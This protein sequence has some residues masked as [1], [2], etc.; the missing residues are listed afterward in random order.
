[1]IAP[2]NDG[3]GAGEVCGEKSRPRGGARDGRRA[4]G[5]SEDGGSQPILSELLGKAAGEPL[6]DEVSAVR[7][8]F[9]LLGF[10]L[11]A[12]FICQPTLSDP[13]VEQTDLFLFNN[14]KSIINNFLMRSLMQK[15]IQW[16]LITL[17]GY[18]DSEKNW[19]LDWL[20]S[21]FGKEQ[22]SFSIEQ[23]KSADLLMFGRITYEGMA[24]YWQTATGKWR[25][26]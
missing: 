10:L 6:Q 22:E 9:E 14:Q 2:R 24:A 5:G 3:P 16:N 4:W 1:M 13:R 8:L 18:F 11:G 20:H 25:T 26:T 7:V 15:L 12:A 23:L 21:Y 17:D 19:E